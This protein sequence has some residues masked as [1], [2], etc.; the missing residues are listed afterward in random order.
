MVK[1]H[2][3]GR[4][5]RQ[6]DTPYDMFTHIYVLSLRSCAD[7]YT[8]WIYIIIYYIDAV[9][10]FSQRYIVEHAKANL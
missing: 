1:A 10:R 4:H 5:N 6:C 7:K 8:R 2:N 9:H 3:F